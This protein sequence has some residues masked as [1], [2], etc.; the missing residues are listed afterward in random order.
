[1]ICSSIYAF[2]FVLTR[3]TFYL[4]SAMICTFMNLP[5]CLP[6]EKTC[7]RLAPPL[8]TQGSIP[9]LPGALIERAC[10]IID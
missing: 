8:Y 7:A 1:M 5:K 3:F 6:R 4:D 9:E 10:S 2:C